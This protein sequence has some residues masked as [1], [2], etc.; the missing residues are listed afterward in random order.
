[1]VRHMVRNPDD[2]AEITQDAFVRAF[3]A[4]PR[5]DPQYTFR[6][7]ILR[8][9]SNQAIDFLRKHRPKM[10][11]IDEPIEGKE[12]AIPREL[13]SAD[14]LPDAAVA[15]ADEIR[16]VQWG[17]AQLSPAHRQVLLLLSQEQLSYEEIAALLEEPIGTVKARIHR[18][19]EALRIILAP[20]MGGGPE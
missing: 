5:F 11:S 4:L 7:W 9:A 19:R 1:M 13:A 20:H 18:A 8:I 6:A 15:E 10:V 17:L 12:G 16:L 2:A 14:R 3:G